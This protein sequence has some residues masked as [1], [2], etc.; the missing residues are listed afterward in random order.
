[1]SRALAARGH[2]CSVLTL[3]IGITEQYRKIHSQSTLIALPCIWRRFY[4]PAPKFSVISDAVQN[5]D[6]VHLMGHWT[7]INAV[8]YFFIRRFHKKYVVCP[9]GALPIFGRSRFIKQ[10]YNFFVGTRLVRN[11]NAHFA[12]ALS[13][14]AHF[15]AYGVSP[16]RVLHV[17]NGITPVELNPEML[18][19]RSLLKISDS[20][21]ILFIG[22]LNLIKGPDL[23]VEAF[24]LIKDQ[25]PNHQLVLAGPDE[26]LKASLILNSRALGIENRVHF[27]GYIG[28]ANKNELLIHADLMVIPSRQEAMS[29]VVLEA[30]LANIPVVLTDQCGLNELQDIQAATVVKVSALDIADGIQSALSNREVSLKA[31]NNLKKYI[32]EHFLWEKIGLKLETLFKLL[33]KE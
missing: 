21:Y 11:A 18:N 14:V 30:G 20:P 7:I 15:E 23:L 16:L 4:L 26:G 32:T 5:A 31:A 22:R 13:E 12:I 33:L 28:G 3:D 1:M 29:I 10:L 27:V 2:S 6:V 24:G 25:F 19:I 9:A 8:A 17:P